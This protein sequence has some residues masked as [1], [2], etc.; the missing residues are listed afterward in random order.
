MLPIARDGFRILAIFF[1]IFAISLIWQNVYVSGPLFVLFLF[2]VTFFRDFDRT[3][4]YDP[5]IAYSPADGTISQINEVEWDGKPY[6]QVV[7]FLS[8]FNCHIN[9]IPLKGTVVSTDHFTG[10]FYVAMRKDIDEKNERQITVFDTDKGRIKV[11]QI[12]GAIA[13]RI[14]CRL[15]PKQCVEV[16]NRFGLIKFGSRTDLWVPRSAEILVKKGDKVRGA[17]TEMVRFQ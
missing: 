10:K 3:K 8:V 13:R 16:G 7:I 14:V 9:R 15:K 2:V 11:A 17:L 5:N 1:M 4:D 6:T 12:T